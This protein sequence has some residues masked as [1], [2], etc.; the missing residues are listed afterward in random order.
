MYT[1][2]L[3]GYCII[4]NNDPPRYK[5]KRETYFKVVNLGKS[6][7]KELAEAR[8]AEY[9]LAAHGGV[10]GD[11]KTWPTSYRRMLAWDAMGELQRFLPNAR[12]SAGFF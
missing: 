1:A 12:L 3:N 2:Q 4:V 10:Q 8:I 6:F 11:P 5:A 9:L 7:T